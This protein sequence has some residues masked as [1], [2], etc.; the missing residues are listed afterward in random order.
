[1]VC[2]MSDTELLSCKVGYLA[3]ELFVAINLF[4]YRSAHLKTVASETRII[5]TLYEAVNYP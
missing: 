1:M 3:A 5:T 4:F 2:Y